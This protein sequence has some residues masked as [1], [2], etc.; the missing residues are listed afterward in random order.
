MASDISQT[1]ERLKTL[2]TTTG[3]PALHEAIS[4]LE[5]ISV[6]NITNST[7]VAIGRNIRMIVNQLNLPAETA[8][9][10][11]DIRNT[12]GAALGLNPNRYSLDA[13]L[14]DKA[15]DFVGR[16]YVFD[17]I[18]EFI[19]DHRSGY[20]IIEG[21]PGMGKSS[22][23]AEY[24][25]RTGCISHFNVRASGITTARQFLENVCTQIIVDFGLPYPNLPPEATQDGVFLLKLLQ[26]V[27]TGLEGGE[28]LLIAVDALDEVDVTSHQQGANILYLPPVLPDNVYFILT[29]RDVDLHLVS[30]SPQRELDLMTHPA[31]NREDVEFYIRR[32]IEH[33]Q[34]QAWIV[35]QKMTEQE[36]VS[37]LAD[38]SESNFMYLRYVMPEIESGM[39]QDLDIQRLPTG[40]TGYYED[41]WLRMGMQAKPLPRVKIR[42]VY[43]MC[44]VR[45]PVSR[46]L[47]SEFATNEEMRVDELTVQ[48]VLD[49]WSQFLHEQLS[50]D[51]TRYS[52]Y[53]S[54]FRDFL[55]RKDIVQAARV[56]IKDIN[57]LIADNLWVQL[58]GKEDRLPA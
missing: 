57:A 56:T 11:L 39:Y 1:I 10:L 45:Q 9:M 35:R 42:I 3:D 15:R 34:L 55:H 6:G 13:V 5:T 17:S 26:E 21:D 47:I 49:E 22:I 18:N 50:T 23:L 54:S 43:V 14:T 4:A 58:F 12:L 44:E 52:I 33:P 28:K 40:L 24:V 37:Q 27:S 8:A 46:K 32:N 51:G 19:N 2:A 53:H 7:G 41:H 31:E 25:R 30:Q 29:R 48:E 38:L 36:F 20:F 16:A